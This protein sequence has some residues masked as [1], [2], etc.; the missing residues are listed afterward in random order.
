MLTRIYVGVDISKNWFDVC[1]H[2]SKE[3]V[4]DRYTN[5]QE[6]CLKF[7][8]EV[9]L[10]ARRPHVCMEHTGGYERRLAMAC[11]QAGVMVS[12]V[13]GARIRHFR[14]S[15]GHARNGTDKDSAIAI[16]RYCKER[17]PERWFPLPDEWRKL[18]ELVR[19]RERLIESRTQWSCRAC[20][21][22]EDPLVMAQRRSIRQV[23]GAEVREIDKALSAHVAA[24]PCLARAVQLLDSIPGIAFRAAVRILAETGPIGGYLSARDYALSAGL[25]PIIDHSGQNTP[26]G[27]LPVYGN[28]EL[29]CALYMPAVVSLR[30]KKGVW[31]HMDR[32]GSRGG[33]LKMTVLTA[34]MRKLA[35]VIYG[36]LK[37]E[38]PFDED[39][40]DNPGK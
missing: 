2:S 32:V 37:R 25:V 40:M 21:V 20:S 26:A 9:R 5:S 33:K 6:G 38:V 18:R 28:R 4:V 7:I 13:D 15:F 19:H 1:I 29:R 16:A 30:I 8:E 23:L 17:R 39:M 36:V 34:G 22:V 12:L 11:I 14:R 24:H 10:L 35:H 31:T 27:K 3:P